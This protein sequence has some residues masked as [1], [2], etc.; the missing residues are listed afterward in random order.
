MKQSGAFLARPML[1]LTVALV[2]LNLRPF[3]TSIG[4]LVSKIRAGTGLSL[5]GI[6]LLTL[7]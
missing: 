1:I 3:M 5:Q 6:A 7:L 2:G 4:P